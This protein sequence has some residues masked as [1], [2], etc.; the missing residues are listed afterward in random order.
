MASRTNAVLGIKIEAEVTKRSSKAFIA[1]L[2]ILM[3]DNKM[4]K[5]VK[6]HLDNDY[7]L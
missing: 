5:S 1:C 7:L 4:H 3:A 6:G 2:F